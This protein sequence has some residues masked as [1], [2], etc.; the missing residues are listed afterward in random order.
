[1]K[2]RRSEEE[3]IVIHKCRR[4]S[5]VEIMNKKVKRCTSTSKQQQV[6]TEKTK[7]KEDICL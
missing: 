5:R 1:M 3:H 2:R 6:P 4:R 7:T